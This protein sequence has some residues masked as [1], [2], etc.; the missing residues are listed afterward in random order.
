MKERLPRT[1]S[2][3]AVQE[4]YR[5]LE[6]PEVPLAHYQLGVLLKIDTSHGGLAWLSQNRAPF[7]TAADGILGYIALEWGLK[8]DKFPA[9][10]GRLSTLCQ[11]LARFCDRY[12][13]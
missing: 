7:L 10:T 2:S 6:T 9:D 4:W 1:F 8:D 11:E 3:E 5:G 12:V 13:H